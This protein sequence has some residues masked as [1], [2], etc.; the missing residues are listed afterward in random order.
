VGDHNAANAAMNS[1]RTIKKLVFDERYI[2]SE[3]KYIKMLR[4]EL[5]RIEVPKKK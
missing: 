5:Q 1:L 2:N 3:N 4:T